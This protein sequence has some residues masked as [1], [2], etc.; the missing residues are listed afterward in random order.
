MPEPTAE[1]RALMQQAAMLRAQGETWE[2]V[3]QAVNRSYST[4]S[5]WSSE[6]PKVWNGYLVEAIESILPTLEQ[7]ALFTAQRGLREDDN[8]MQAARMLLEHVRK[9]RGE[10]LKVSGGDGGPLTINIVQAEPPAD[11][12]EPGD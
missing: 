3:G 11:S 6:Y 2:T 12:D 9:L 5:H 1:T 10:R 8:K 4:C 7:E